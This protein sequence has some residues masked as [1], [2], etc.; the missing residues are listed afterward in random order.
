MP[1]IPKETT[2][3]PQFWYAG[4]AARVSEAS[5]AHS[6]ID[7][8][9]TSPGPC[10]SSRKSLSSPGRPD[11]EGSVDGRRVPAGRGYFPVGGV[12]LRK[13]PAMES[14]PE[15]WMDP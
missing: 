1:S 8:Q 12:R 2:L 4:C 6:L 5:T 11:R 15:Y 9:H 7:S 13:V 14:L 10:K 3:S